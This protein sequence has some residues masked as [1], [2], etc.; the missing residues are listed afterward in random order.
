MA[1]R[2]LLL[3]GL[4]VLLQPLWGFPRPGKEHRLLLRASCLAFVN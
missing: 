2:L 4:L 1:S 3:L